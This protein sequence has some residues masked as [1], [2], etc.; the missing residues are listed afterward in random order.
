MTIKPLLAEPHTHNETQLE[1]AATH[2]A[3]LT[4]CPAKQIE[5]LTLAVIAGR[6]DQLAE[7]R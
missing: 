6:I 5:L 3:T 2:V 4:A 1:H 7:N